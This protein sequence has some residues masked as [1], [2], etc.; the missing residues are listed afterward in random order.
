MRLLPGNKNDSSSDD[1]EI[2]ETEIE[3]NAPVVRVDAAG[4]IPQGRSRR[5]T[6]KIRIGDVID[7]RED[8]G[9]WYPAEV[10]E[11]C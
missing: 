2:P 5:P 7:V 6:R 4:G 8:D 1:D 3:N 9:I 11:L 10:S